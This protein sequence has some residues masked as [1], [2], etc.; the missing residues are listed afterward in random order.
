MFAGAC[1]PLFR[2]R[3]RYR[4]D[5]RERWK[6]GSLQ[7]SCSARLP[8]RAGH[9]L[10]WQ[11]SQP[12]LW[13]CAFLSS[14]QDCLSRNN[15]RRC[16]PAPKASPQW[17]AVSW[18]SKQAWRAPM[19]AFIS[20]HWPLCCPS[21]AHSST[22]VS[23]IK[24]FDSRPSPDAA[25]GSRRLMPPLPGPDNHDRSQVCSTLP[26]IEAETAH[27]PVGQQTAVVPF[28]ECRR[29]HCQQLHEL[30]AVNVGGHHPAQPRIL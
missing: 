28:F 13:R 15:P 11:S 22:D 5:P 6:T 24:E 29:V 18:S 19:S 16:G 20:W 17:S 26:M 25:G 4:A 23:V 14:A 9:S 8:G 12:A 3:A 10:S 27:A 2:A 7:H 1:V 30:T 21:W